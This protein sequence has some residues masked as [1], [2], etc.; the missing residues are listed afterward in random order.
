[1]NME[2]LAAEINNLYRENPSTAESSIENLLQRAWERDPPS[3]WPARLGELIEHCRGEGPDQEAKKQSETGEFPRLLSLL[4][5]ERVSEL[6]LRSEEFMDKL[7]R[8]LNTLFDTLNQIIGVIHTTFLGQKG[9]METIRLIIG[10]ALKGEEQSDSLQNYLNQI[11]E[12]FLI[13]HRAFRHAAQKKIRDILS[14]LDPEHISQLGEGT[15]DFSPFHKGK[16]FEIYK[17]EFLKC[18]G[19][20]ESGRLMEEVLR[21]FEK[22]CQKQYQGGRG[23]SS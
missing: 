4:L 5:G 6:D 14:A 18:K 2:A 15:F 12:A 17:E 22:N 1:M 9:E 16:L 13:S 8:S 10:S 11:R 23:R 7:A 21:E 19:W 3:E 20:V